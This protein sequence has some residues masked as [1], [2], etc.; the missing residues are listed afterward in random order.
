MVKSKRTISPIIGALI[1]IVIVF[2]LGIVIYSF[3]TGFIPG[4]ATTEI[5]LKAEGIAIEDDLK[6]IVTVTVLNDGNVPLKIKELRILKPAVDEEVCYY[7]VKGLTGSGSSSTGFIFTVTG[8]P[9]LNAGQSIELIFAQIGKITSIKFGGKE[10]L[11]AI[12][13]ENIN[14]EEIFETLTVQISSF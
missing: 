14:G 7:S 8:N 6:S 11:I 9:T 3:M 5:S 12:I 1:L 10:I 13:A 2:I 4:I